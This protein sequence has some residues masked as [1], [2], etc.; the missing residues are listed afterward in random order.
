MGI[1]PQGFGY[2]QKLYNIQPPF[3]ALVLGN[4]RM[5]LS[6]LLGEVALGESSFLPD[7]NQ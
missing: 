2:I 5:N 4:I 6:Q 1:N 3:S 7:R